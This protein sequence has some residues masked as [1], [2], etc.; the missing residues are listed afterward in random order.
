MHDADNDLLYRQYE[1][2]MHIVGSILRLN[3][4]TPE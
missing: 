4:L 3:T 1:M 2:N